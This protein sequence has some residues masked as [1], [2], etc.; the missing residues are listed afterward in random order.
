MNSDDK[1]QLVSPSPG[2]R[3]MTDLHYA[4]YCGDA[5]ALR[6]SLSAAPDPNAQDTYRGY[7]ALHW[8][9]DMA[10]TGGPRLKMLRMLIKAGADP[11]IVSGTGQTAH[12]L[13]LEAGTSVGRRLATELS[14]LTKR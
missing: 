12:D 1:P 8:L 14:K 7:T 10:A 6:T 5:D 11:A 13:A 9:A 4:A 2:F 3:D